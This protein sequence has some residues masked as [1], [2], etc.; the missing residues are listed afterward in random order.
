MPKI[1]SRAAVSSVLTLAIGAALLLSCAA[2]DAAAPPGGSGTE[3]SGAGGSGG[4]GD[5]ACFTAGETRTCSIHNAFGCLEGTQSCEDG[6]WSA[7]TFAL[8]ATDRVLVPPGAQGAAP[9]A[10]TEARSRSG[11][12]GRVGRP[13]GVVDRAIGDAC[14]VDS[15]CG[16]GQYCAATDL[17]AATVTCAHTV[18]CPPGEY[19]GDGGLCA[20]VARCGEDDT[21][22]NKCDTECRALEPQ[23]L[24]FGAPGTAFGYEVGDLGGLPATALSRGLPDSCGTG[25]TSDCQLDHHCDAGVCV[26]WPANDW[27]A[28]GGKPDATLGVPCE[29][30][31][32]VCNRGDGFLSLTSSDKIQWKVDPTLTDVS[33][34]ACGGITSGGTGSC[35]M[36]TGLPPLGP[37]ECASVPCAGIPDGAW[38]KAKFGGPECNCNNDWT[39]NVD[40]MACGAPT[41][42]GGVNLSAGPVDLSMLTWV[43]RSLTMV[44]SRQN[45]VCRGLRTFVNDVANTG[46]NFEYKEWPDVAIGHS[47]GTTGSCLNTDWLGR[48]ACWGAPGNGS[49]VP[50]TTLP[51]NVI[52]C[53]FPGVGNAKYLSGTE[54]STPILGGLRGARHRA[55]IEKAAHP[56]RA[57]VIVLVTDAV[58]VGGTHPCLATGAIRTEVDDAQDE[59]IYTAVVAIDVSCPSAACTQAKDIANRGGTGLPVF[60]TGSGTPTALTEALNDIR[61]RFSCSRK[62]PDPLPA[63]V[64]AS[65][66]GVTWNNGGT[67][68]PFVDVGSSGGC[69]SATNQFFFDGTDTISLCSDT[70]SVVTGAIGS[71][72]E[73]TVPC[74]PQVAPVTGGDSFSVPPG[75]C[76]Q[77]TF[78]KWTQMVATASFP[79]ST[80]IA[81]RAHTRTLSTDAWPPG[82]ESIITLNAG[83][84]GGANPIDLFTPLD[85][86]FQAYGE[87]I[88]FEF[89]STTDRI[90]TNA[91]GF[92][93]TT[94]APTMSDYEVYFTCAATE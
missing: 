27:Q 1:S 26:P 76:P 94:V 78:P 92:D 71:N 3:T 90:D 19:C 23:P 83:N 11:E 57:V 39:W 42:G 40:P 88:A 35:A 41:C 55:R 70:C 38:L 93:D 22:A 68:T 45:T 2:D 89:E 87:G 69:T 30:T 91:D 14:S 37:G 63:G 80:S 75:T 8:T 29:D 24:D 82:W 25:T 74:G 47:C 46:I 64:F 60:L 4:S 33:E 52:P 7:C 9:G 58:E 65:D 59:G 36:P 21:Q 28:C 5:E 62:V 15:G 6:T 10:P 77:G 32:P 17:C 31:V 50:P 54:Y 73:F 12:G 67:A 18:D 34:N 48:E 61:N 49:F 86:V 56:D 72:V 85:A 51:A 81:I 66:L 43:D 16:G 13:P 53:T 79:G 84:I 44:A 20:A